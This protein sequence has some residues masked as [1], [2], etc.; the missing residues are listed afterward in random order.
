[1]KHRRKGKATKSKVSGQFLTLN[2]SSE[3]PANTFF[4]GGGRVHSLFSREKVSYLPRMC[5]KISEDFQT[6]RLEEFL[7]FCT[8]FLP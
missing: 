8:F 3:K 1:M 4:F 2:F 6:F 5:Q 7:T